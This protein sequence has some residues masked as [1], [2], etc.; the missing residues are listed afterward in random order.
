MS[1]SFES[2]VAADEHSALPHYNPE[3]GEGN[4]TITRQSVLLLD[5]GAHY[6]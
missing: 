4:K 2:V 6:K 3:N 5:S 1:L